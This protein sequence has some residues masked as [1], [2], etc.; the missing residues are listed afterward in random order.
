MFSRTK[1]NQLNQR[2][3]TKLISNFNQSNI[4]LHYERPRLDCRELQNKKTEN[5]RITVRTGLCDHLSS[6][7][8]AFLKCVSSIPLIAPDGFQIYLKCFYART[9]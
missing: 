5:D 7:D 6:T 3:I 1:S 8:V 4:L 9:M 2:K